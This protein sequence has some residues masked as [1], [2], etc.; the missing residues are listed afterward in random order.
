MPHSCR[1]PDDGARL[2]SEFIITWFRRHP[3][4]DLSDFPREAVLALIQRFGLESLRETQG[5][6]TLRDIARR[7]LDDRRICWEQYPVAR[8][9]VTVL[10]TLGQPR[11][12]DEYLSLS[13]F[14]TP[15]A[16][17]YAH[18]AA[19]YALATIC[20]IS[21]NLYAD[22]AALGASTD[23]LARIQALCNLAEVLAASS[24]HVNGPWLKYSVLPDTP[25]HQE[26]LLIPLPRPRNKPFGRPCRT[27]EK[28]FAC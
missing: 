12:Y 8:H 6:D 27:G 24:S 7:V 13:L 20:G 22:Q 2:L 5:A 28:L 25:L 17:L 19:S 10:G 21:Q 3:V 18:D 16:E 9:L 1:E 14:D 26:A 15:L 11:I 4:P 23:R